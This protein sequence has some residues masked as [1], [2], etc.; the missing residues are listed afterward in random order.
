VLVAVVGAGGAMRCRTMSA[1]RTMSLAR[2]AL[3][4]RDRRFAPEEHRHPIIFCNG[5]S[6]LL[7]HA[8][9]HDGLARLLA[10]GLPP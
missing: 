5:L 6:G 8:L 10:R 2:H 9:F 4:P 1:C 7:Y 3:V